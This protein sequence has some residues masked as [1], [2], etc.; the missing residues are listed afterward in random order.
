MSSVDQP[1]LSPSTADSWTAFS[2]QYF[3]GSYEHPFLDLCGEGDS[4]DSSVEEG[5]S[6]E[7]A[8]D[9]MESTAPPLRSLSGP[10]EVVDSEN[11]V[12]SSPNSQG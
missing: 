1:V 2:D 10:V 12:D 4:S 8:R 7:S 5:V 3:E 6:G 11:S 9:L